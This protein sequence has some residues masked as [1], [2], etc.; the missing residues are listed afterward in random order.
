MSKAVSRV[1]SWTII[2]LDQLLPPGSS[3]LPESWWATYAF[4]SVL[5][6]MGF[7]LTLNVT[8]KAVVSYTAISPLPYWRFNFCCTFL[9]VA[10]TGR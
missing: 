8:I 9:G 6:R 5:L 3:N 1:M 10:S 4:C 2:Y 7:T